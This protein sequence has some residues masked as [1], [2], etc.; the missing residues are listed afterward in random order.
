MFLL[1]NFRLYILAFNVEEAWAIYAVVLIGGFAG[2]I[3]WTAEGNYI[4]C[5]SSSETISRNVSIF[6]AFLQSS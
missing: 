4:V 6:W 5:N 3:L 1:N 2:G